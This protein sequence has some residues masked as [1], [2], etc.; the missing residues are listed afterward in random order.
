MDDVLVK[1]LRSRQ[2]EGKRPMEEQGHENPRRRE[3]LEGRMESLVSNDEGQRLRR[4]HRSWQLRDHWSHFQLCDQVRNHIAR[5]GEVNGR[6]R[7]G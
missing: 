7:C 5:S 6:R 1:R 2:V 4:G 3:H